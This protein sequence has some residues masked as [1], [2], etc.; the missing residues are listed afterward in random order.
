V[1]I[2]ELLQFLPTFTAKTLEVAEV[3][4]LPPI[5]VHHTELVLI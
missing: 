2:S 5:V 3:L 1:H 4:C